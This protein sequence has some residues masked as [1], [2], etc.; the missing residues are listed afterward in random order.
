MDSQTP[1]STECCK[2]D[3]WFKI[4][5]III[6]ILIVIGLF[7]NMYLLL[8]KQKSPEQ[9]KILPAPTTVQVIITPTSVVPTL[10][11]DETANWK[12]F[13]SNKYQFSFRYPE[14]L[15]EE[16][17]TAVP[18]GD[19][20]LSD[21]KN[22]GETGYSI[23]AIAENNSSGLS[24]KEFATKDYGEDIKKLFMFTK[25]SLADYTVYTTES[26]PSRSGTVE[27]FITK[28]DAKYIH[29][30]FMPY[31]PENPF[32]KQTDYKKTFDQIL[33]TFRFD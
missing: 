22:L 20:C 5:V 21:K 9:S 2:N 25:K 14:D 12:T 27:V 3:R 11:A 8:K 4:S 33:S 23:C 28:D 32:P 15:F 26:L 31:S 24:F 30:R 7:G 10:T 13:V 19:I 29:F 16:R 1:I 17:R 18:E 6:G